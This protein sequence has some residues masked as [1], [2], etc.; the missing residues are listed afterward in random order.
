MT[1]VEHDGRWVLIVG[2]I[3]VLLGAAFAVISWQAFVARG[4]P[5]LV[6]GWDISTV[7]E[8]VVWGE[9]EGVRLIGDFRCVDDFDPD[10]AIQ[11]QAALVLENGGS[12]PAFVGA[13]VGAGVVCNNG[14]TEFTV[15]WANLPAAFEL[16]SDDVARIRY[17]A[18]PDGHVSV[19]VESNSF[20]ILAP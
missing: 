12:I 3:T 1:T 4:A 16:T 11:F 13:K 18:S 6:S 9:G 7:D 2:F 14:P 20:P 15:R 10:T 8:S 19:P 5:V 17:S